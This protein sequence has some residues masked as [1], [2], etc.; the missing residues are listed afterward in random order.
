M[1]TLQANIG[2]LE[3]QLKV[4][5]AKLDVLIANAEVAGAQTKLDYR[6][7]IDDLAAKHEAAQSK[8]NQLKQAGIGKWEVLKAEI[9]SAWKDLDD[10]FR[11]T[12]H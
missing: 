2:K 11:E 1:Q 5:R 3:A 4:W 12:K 8:L 9:E 7:H 6:R 10:A